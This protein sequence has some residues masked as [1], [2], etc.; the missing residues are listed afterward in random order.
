M[1]D[2]IINRFE[3]C[4]KCLKGHIDNNTITDIF[5][6][7]I[8][9]SAIDDLDFILKEGNTEQWHNTPAIVAKESNWMEGFANNVHNV[10]NDCKFKF[11]H[12]VIGGNND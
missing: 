5:I 9:C 3:L 2:N 4:R 8:I 11:E 1:D 10:C 12:T 7:G 6:N